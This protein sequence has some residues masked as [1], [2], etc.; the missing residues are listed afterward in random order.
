M[1]KLKLGAVVYALVAAASLVSAGSVFHG[2]GAYADAD[3]WYRTVV[4]I[5]LA[6]TGALFAVGAVTRRGL[7][8]DDGPRICRDGWIVVI[9]LAC[10]AFVVTFLDDQGG[11]VPP[12]P[13]LAAAFVPHWVRR[14]QES[15]YEGRDEAERELKSVEPDGV[16]P[17]SV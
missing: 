2:A 14:L 1:P 5:V 9:A 8:S 15:Y 4:A 13:N 11:S 6:L 12:F 16:R 10:C 7:I 3:H 17:P